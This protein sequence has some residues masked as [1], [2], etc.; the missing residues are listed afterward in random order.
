MSGF[1]FGPHNRFNMPNKPNRDKRNSG[2]AGGAKR[3]QTRRQTP[4]GPQS[5]ATLLTH[6]DAL[7]PQLTQQLALQQ[8]WRAWL[9]ARLPEALSQKVTGAVEQDGCLTVLAA[10]AAWGARLRYAVK[11]LEEEIRAHAPQ[12]AVIRV[13]VS[14]PP[15]AKS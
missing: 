12:L 7:S 2:S 9:E 6:S 8:H 3:R 10:S 1:A 13:R 15:P 5:A 4:T 11:E 14:R